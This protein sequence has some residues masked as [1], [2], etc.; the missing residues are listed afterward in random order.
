MDVMEATPEE[1]RSIV[2]D[3]AALLGRWR[4]GW[5][6][7][8][9]IDRLVMVDGYNCVAGQVFGNWWRTPEVI[10]QHPAFAGDLSVCDEADK[11][12][13]LR[14]LWVEYIRATRATCDA[15]LAA[16]DVSHTA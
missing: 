4:I 11:L 9:D 6:D 12:E 13:E 15:A 8:V 7:R 3:G 2:A 14:L 16:M 10:R 1:L 5:I